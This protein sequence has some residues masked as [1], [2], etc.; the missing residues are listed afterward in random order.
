MDFVEEKPTSSGGKVAETIATQLDA[1]EPD[2]RRA[3]FLKGRMATTVYGLLNK[4]PDELYPKDSP[5]GSC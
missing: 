2:V 1:V 5:M 4:I 3:N